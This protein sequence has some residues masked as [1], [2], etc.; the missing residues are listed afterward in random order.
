MINLFFQI[1]TIFTAGVIAHWLK[2][3]EEGKVSRNKISLVFFV[4]FLVSAQATL[5]YYYKIPHFKLGIST[6]FYANVACI[7]LMSAI[8]IKTTTS[9]ELLEEY[10]AWMRWLISIFLITY[11]IALTMDY[12]NTKKVF[13]RM[14]L[15]V[16][17]FL[18]TRYYPSV[19]DNLNRRRVDDESIN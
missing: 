15:A 2:K 9:D 7:C 18:F 16:V 5:L 12:S 1:W 11:L 8:I 4:A 6:I 17:A 19:M 10:K 14:L 13:E 3:V